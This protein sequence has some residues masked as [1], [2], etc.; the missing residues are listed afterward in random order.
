[1][2]K[3]K[4][5]GFTLVEVLLAAGILAT[6]LCGILATYISCFELASTS[7]NLTLAI[8]SA[9]M[10]I[11]EIRD[12]AFSGIFTDY[13]NQ[14]FTVDEIIPG[15]SQGIIYV[16]NSN[17]ELLK[18]TISVCW[19]QGAS[20]IIGEDKDLDGILDAG[21]DAN[22]NNMIDSPAQLVTLITAR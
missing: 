14:T 20:R 12:Y 5:L 1:M 6:T 4:D 21:E 17:P 11:E 9:Q 13:N 3:S 19:R 16:D 15:N 10:R 7:K 8:N 2:K 18:V 22:G